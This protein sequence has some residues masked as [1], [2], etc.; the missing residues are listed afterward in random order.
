MRPLRHALVLTVTAGLALSMLSAC[1]DDATPAASSPNSTATAT[2]GGDAPAAGEAFDPCKK[3]T[4]AEIG[5]I[6]GFTVVMKEVP[7]GGCSYD[8]A[9]DP[10]ATTI[11]IDEGETNAGGGIESAKQGS[12]GTIAGEP[13]ALS[14]V[15]DAAYIVV[16]K[17]KALGKNSF[18]A[19]A[20]LEIKGQLIMVTVIQLG[21]ATKDQVTKFV[22]E[23]T[24]L[25]ASKV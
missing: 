17:G 22:T 9:D 7:G 6:V 16:G 3:I 8:P 21:N 5:A 25:V 2:T 18:Q 19:Q 20:G 23:A 15:G 14:G 13:V 10:R 4:A 11:S 24:K 12:T 1:G